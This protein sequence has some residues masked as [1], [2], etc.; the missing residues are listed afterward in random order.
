MAEDE[1]PLTEPLAAP[2]TA[3]LAAP[4]APVAAPLASPLAA[5]VALPLVRREEP[6]S[7]D[8][9]NKEATFAALAVDF[10]FNDKVKNLFLKGHMEN[11]EDFRYYFADEKEV[12]AFVATDESLRGPEL[13]LQIS[14]V[15]RAWTAVRQKGLLTATP[16]HQWQNSTIFLKREHSEK[17]RCSSGNGT[18]QD[19]RWR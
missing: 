5:P 4:E 14:R 19:T 18:K 8:R 2:L 7:T 15:R 11:L 6:S 3:P 12:D 10:G 16:F 1:A 9:G 17:S 13:R